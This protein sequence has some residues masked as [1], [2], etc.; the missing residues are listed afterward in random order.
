M[1][2]S[3]SSDDKDKSGSKTET[4]IILKDE[5]NTIITLKDTKRPAITL[6]KPSASTIMS[7]RGEDV[8]AI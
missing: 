7:R 6:S 3:C 1:G 8:I 5:S 4:L 2:G